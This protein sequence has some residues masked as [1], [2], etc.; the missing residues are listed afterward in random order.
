MQK[1]AGSYLLRDRIF[2]HGKKK[3]TQG[4]SMF[5]Y[6]LFELSLDDLP[7]AIGEKVRECLEA[8][9]EGNQPPSREE[10]KKINDPMIQLAGEKTTKGFFTKVK[11][12]PINLTN[13]RIT[14]FP[15]ENHGW[16]DGFK[17]TQHPN[18]ELDYGS[19]TN[20]DLGK[21]LLKA[22]ELSSIV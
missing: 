3:T 20:E 11:D 18:I 13:N 10:L 8:F 16:K 21:A 9:L 6:P 2:I 7:E 17:N 15:T 12:V 14:F 1:K 19:A 4:L 5:S 22:F